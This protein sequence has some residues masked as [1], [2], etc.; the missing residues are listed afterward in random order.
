MKFTMKFSMKLNK[1]QINYLII[2]LIK[3]NTDEIQMKNK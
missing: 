2:K 1:K 3:S